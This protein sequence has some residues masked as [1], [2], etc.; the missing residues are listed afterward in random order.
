MIKNDFITRSKFEEY[1]VLKNDWINL[2]L[3][4]EYKSLI[5][6]QI[7]LLRIESYFNY[8]IRLLYQEDYKKT[9]RKLDIN[10]LLKEYY[11]TSTKILKENAS[12]ILDDTLDV[13]DTFQTSFEWKEHHLYYGKQLELIIQTVLDTVNYSTEIKDILGIGTAEN[14][15]LS[16]KSAQFC[17]NLVMI[18]Y[19][20]ASKRIEDEFLNSNFFG[21]EIMEFN[22]S[23]ELIIYLTPKG[24]I[25]APEY[26]S[27][28]KAEDRNEELSKQLSKIGIQTINNQEL[29]QKYFTSTILSFNN[30]LYYH[31]EQINFNYSTFFNKRINRKHYGSIILETQ[32]NYMKIK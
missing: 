20:S 22:E 21:V 27:K 15:Y 25:E 14:P 29:K 2:N 32:G 28:F 9:D 12:I 6:S 10:I 18:A 11:E 1:H 31:Y 5:Y 26:F 7:P 17:Q 4:K 30:I 3:S 16:I 13:S 24:M 23:E 19:C 8:I